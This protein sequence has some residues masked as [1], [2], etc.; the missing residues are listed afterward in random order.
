MSSVNVRIS[1]N[2]FCLLRR[3]APGLDL[4]DALTDF[5]HFLDLRLEWVMSA[6][7]VSGFMLHTR[8]TGKSGVVL[9]VVELASL[10]SP[11]LPA[12]P[13]GAEL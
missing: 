8:N 7:C 4:G 2:L 11:V 12:F 13:R 9:A 3:K 10:W 5:I 6:Y 1:F